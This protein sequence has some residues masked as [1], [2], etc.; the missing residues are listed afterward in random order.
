MRIGQQ[1][2]FQEIFNTCCESLKKYNYVDFSLRFRISLARVNK[3]NIGREK[4]E[5]PG[6]F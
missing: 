3:K 6:K 1:V 2:L 5:K 4:P